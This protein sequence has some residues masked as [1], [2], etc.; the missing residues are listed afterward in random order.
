MPMMYNLMRKVNGHLSTLFFKKQNMRA[1]FFRNYAV[2]HHLGKGF[3]D[4]DIA[5]LT[6]KNDWGQR[7]SEISSKATDTWFP[8]QEL[9]LCT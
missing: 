3:S 2:S 7:I 8:S 4:L 5:S 6:H 1:E 9:G